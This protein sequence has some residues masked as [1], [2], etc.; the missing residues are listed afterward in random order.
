MAEPEAWCSR[1]DLRHGVAEPEAQRGRADLRCG[2]A[3]DL[4]HGVA[5]PDSYLLPGTEGLPHF[6]ADHDNG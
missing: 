4:R 5:E 2:R 6:V 3:V 1:A